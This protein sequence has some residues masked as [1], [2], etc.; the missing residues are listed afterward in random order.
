MKIVVSQQDK[1]LNVK[2]C[3]GKLVDKHEIDKAEDFLVAVDKFFKKRKIRPTGLI[4][5]QIGHIEFEN[6]GILTERVIKA[7]IMGLRF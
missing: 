7:I 4:R 5:G 2:F 1:K 6:T 3:Q